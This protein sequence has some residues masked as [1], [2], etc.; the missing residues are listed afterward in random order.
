MEGSSFKA[1]NTTVDL[2]PKE[3]R[4]LALSAESKTDIYATPIPP[5]HH[6]FSA[7]IVY[8][9]ILLS[10]FKSARVTVTAPWTLQYD[11][12]GLILIIPSSNNPS[13]DGQNATSVST[14]PEW[15]KAGIE[16]Y[17]GKPYLSVVGKPRDG[18]CDWSLSTI[19]QSSSGES[20]VTLEMTKYKNALMIWC[21]GPD[22][23]KTLVRKVPWVFLHEVNP[24]LG[25]KR[26][27]AYVGLYAARPDP[28]SQANDNKL[29]VH[30]T[31]FDIDLISV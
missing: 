21:L 15:V 27:S 17:E 26:E 13:P 23:E 10:T 11:Q 31:D 22:N 1:V 2:P 12:G 3:P 20:Q 28:S 6:T 30:F 25:D 24:D 18:W 19:P 16:M 9:Q 29:D 7:P 8:R 4:T 14:H 5:T